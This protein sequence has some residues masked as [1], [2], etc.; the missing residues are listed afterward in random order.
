MLANQYKAAGIASFKKGEYDLSRN[1]LI[2]SINL[3]C[4]EEVVEF[5]RKSEDKM[6]RLRSKYST[7]EAF[8]V[9]PKCGK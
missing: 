5:I 4:D 1:T 8:K 9:P 2:K 6:R 3:K 7:F